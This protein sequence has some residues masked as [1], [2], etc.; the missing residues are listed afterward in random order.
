MIKINLL[1]P[2]IF[3]A[4]TIKRLA[5]VFAV[6]FLV[7]VGAC[8][9]YWNKINKETADWKAKAEVA[10]G[11]LMQANQIKQQAADLRAQIGPITTKIQFFE[12]VKKYNDKYPA[13]Y[14][15][16][17]KF[18]Y[19]KVLY[20]QLTPSGPTL[21]IQA[22]AP[23]LTDA[24][25]YLLNLYKATHIF[26]SVAISGVP[27]FPQQGQAQP[28]I[29][30]GAMP[31]IGMAPG[32]APPPISAAPSGGALGSHASMSRVPNAWALSQTGP[33]TMFVPPMP[34]AGTGGESSIS[35]GY[36]G[37][38]TIERGVSQAEAQR[39]GFSFTVTCVLKPDVD[40]AAPVVPGVAVAAAG[41]PGMP[42]MPGMGG[43]P[44]PGMTMPGMASPPAGPAAKTAPS[45]SPGKAESED[46]ETPRLGGKRGG[47]GK[48][49]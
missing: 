23:S 34:E 49:P 21:T 11:L 15:K 17:A 45:V 29:G 40:I 24:G 13:I 25:R 20:T 44:T 12:D 43:M 14:E 10:N 1:P 37:I 42:G 41:T 32:P 8:L 28:G 2:N 3:E 16:L 7:I 18:T 39:R 4:R 36:G 47:G 33:P 6:V 31:T 38:G 35:T 9:A 19:K 5:V 26:Q 22:Y 30:G 48:L 27:G 46:T